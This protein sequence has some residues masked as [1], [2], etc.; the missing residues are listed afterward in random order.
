MAH[1]QG[2]LLM[3]SRCLMQFIAFSLTASAVY[4][5]NDWI[6]LKFDREHPVK[7]RRP[8]AS[9]QVNPKLALMI[10]GILL[11]LGLSM[12]FVDSFQTGLIVTAYILLNLFYS[13]IAK[14]MLG[15]D[16][17][18]LALFYLLRLF[19]GAMGG[20][21]V[22]TSWFV[23]FFLFFF[24]SL[25]FTKRSMDL[26]HLEGDGSG[27]AYLKQDFRLLEGFGIAS[28]FASL[29]M[30]AQYI[31]LHQ[32]SSLYKNPDFL[33]LLIPMLCVWYVRCMVLSQRG[34]RR[35]DLIE[36]A[37]KDPSSIGLIV[38]GV[39]TWVWAI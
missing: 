20:E 10:G 8:L 25:S 29:L 30:L 2:D 26:A 17:F 33:W 6:D 1:R 3:L 39:L 4:I 7:S 31:S 15:F 24:L 21:V 32:S 23:G 12:G 37:I 28:F 22:L 19:A 36:F 14:K 38:C 5:F 13:L 11:V 35:D 27:R 34:T 16:V 18:I 9:G